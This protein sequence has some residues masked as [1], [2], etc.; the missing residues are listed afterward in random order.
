MQKRDLKKILK[1][2]NSEIVARFC[3]RYGVSKATANVI[4]KDM[5][6]FF[7]LARRADELRREGAQNV[8]EHVD[9]LEPILIIDEMWHT[10]VLYTRDYIDFSCRYF[11]EYFHHDPARVIAP[12]KMIN[13]H[14]EK[15]P[16]K[17]A[18]RE[19]LEIF[20]AFVWQELGESTAKRWFQSFPKKF[21]RKEIYR[22]QA[23]FAD[24]PM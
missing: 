10:F 5:L 12:K 11:G 16:E 19:E 22:R 2:K 7:W 3:V 17:F 6:C 21:S 8:P 13:T 14:A 24:L 18:S 9:I 23:K 4:F 15:V 20:A 1:Y